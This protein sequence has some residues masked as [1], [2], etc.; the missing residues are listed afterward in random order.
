MT[1]P[2]LRPLAATAVT[3]V[4]TGAALS[5]CSSSAN[6]KEAAGGRTI[7][8]AFYPLQYVAERVA[9]D[10]AT[11]TNLTQPGKEPHDL[12]LSFAQVADVNDADLVVYEKGLQADVDDAVRTREGGATVDAT[13]LV[14]LQP[15]THHDES[16]KSSTTETDH[17]G[18]DAGE[19][20]GEG[21]DRDPHFWQDPIRLAT[22][23]DAI[24]DKLG[25]LD[26]AHASE[27]DDNA[28]ALRS[29]L[30]ELDGEFQTGLSSCKRDTIV[31]NHDAFEYLGKYGLHMLPIAGVSPDTEPSAATLTG[32]QRLI[33]KEG[34]T[35][36]FTETLVSKKTADSLA[37]DV[38][39]STAVL[40]P[41]EGLS[42]DDSDADYLSVMR[43][44]LAAI[45]KANDC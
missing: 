31:V 40:D 13:A 1:R 24:A 43:D 35:T 32:L 34:I 25:S 8:T 7:V 12:A 14:D 17:A 19:G 21:G 27:Y 39:V 41:L 5:G 2:L 11:V 36:V 29:D 23:G 44:N 6:D 45:Q 42:S 37:S 16:G 20:I 18:H 4:L 26:P 9:G 28:A 38:G 22:V 10:N 33:R 15:V 30:E 3:V